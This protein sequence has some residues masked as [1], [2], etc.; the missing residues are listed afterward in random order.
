MGSESG[1]EA[2]LTL[3]NTV[4]V[5]DPNY[6]ARIAAIHASLGIPVHDAERRG[7]VLQYE[8][9]ESRLVKIA[10]TAD[11]REIKLLE[12]AAASWHAMRTA[13]AAEGVELVPVSGFRSVARQEEL[14]R[15]K[16]TA[17]VTIDAALHVLAAPGFSEHHTGRAV[18][19]AAPGEPPL[20]ES[21]E[22]TGAFTWLARHAG[23]FGFRMS[24]PKG[25]AAGIAYEPWH[26]RW[27]RG[28]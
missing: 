26:W 2:R 24:F 8:A 11:G 13:A 23:G 1:H 16:L 15:R 9:H 20:E 3:V 12:P 6:S 14:V 22:R 19:L 27:E 18:D 21:F 17:G 25:N 7:L 10:T 28:A 5:P 4:H